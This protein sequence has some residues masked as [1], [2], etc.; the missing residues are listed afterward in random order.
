MAVHSNRSD[1]SNQPRRNLRQ[2]WIV[3]T[4]LL[5][6]AIFS[7]AVFAGV[8]L[9]GVD[10]GRR[11]HAA[12]A[13]V[14]MAS[15]LTAGLVAVVTLRPIPHGPRLGSTLVA[16]AALVLLQTAVGRSSAW[17]TNLMWIHVPL[18]VALVRFASQAVARARRLGAA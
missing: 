6:A 2:S 11:A 18:G 8:M 3:I 4:T 12:N 9:S 5:A 10:W 15:T 13:V 1:D 17:G 7:E 14:L 16:L